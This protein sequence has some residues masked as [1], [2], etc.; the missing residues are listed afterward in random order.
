MHAAGW[1]TVRF[2]IL[3]T[4]FVVVM[5]RRGWG[6]LRRLSQL[7]GLIKER[8]PRAS[9]HLSHRANDV[10]QSLGNEPWQAGRWEGL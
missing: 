9:R 2:A 5:C 6:Q 1:R 3:R 8:S 7:A 4:G 10:Q